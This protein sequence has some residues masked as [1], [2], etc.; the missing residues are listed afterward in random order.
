MKRFGDIFTYESVCFESGQYKNCRLLRDV[1]ADK[2]VY[3]Y[4]HEIF[5]LIV[6]DSNTYEFNFFEE[7]DMYCPIFTIRI[8]S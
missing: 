4:E 6:F 7:F 8:K 1:V 3:A 2:H 5:P